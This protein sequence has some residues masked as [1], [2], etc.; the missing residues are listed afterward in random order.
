VELNGSQWNLIG[1][2]GLNLRH[3]RARAARTRDGIQRWEFPAT[4]DGA[5]HPEPQ[6]AQRIA[7]A[8]Q[9][10]KLAH[11]VERMVVCRFG[12]VR[13][14]GTVVHANRHRGG[15]SA[16]WHVGCSEGSGRIPEVD[17]VDGW[18]ADRN[19]V[20]TE[21]LRDINLSPCVA[22]ECQLVVAK[23]HHEACPNIACVPD[24]SRLR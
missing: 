7:L 15:R 3:L 12:H 24:D 10:C 11:P 22:L 19:L 18:R 16:L 14:S 20:V 4:R 17:N 13:K 2:T 8:G 5:S 21:V 9:P 23:E 6:S 1:L